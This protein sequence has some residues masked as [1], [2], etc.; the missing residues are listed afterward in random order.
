[1]SAFE[2]H[3]DKV[4]DNMIDEITKNANLAYTSLIE[5]SPVNELPESIF[6]NYFLPCFL[7]KTD[8][9]KWVLEWI[10]IAGSP[11]SEVAIVKDGTTQILY[12]VPGMLTTNNLFLQ[13]NEGSMSDIFARHDQINNNMP[14]ESMKYLSSAL[15]HTYGEL[16][17]S[18]SM[19]RTQEAWNHIFQRYNIVTNTPLQN[20]TKPS[21]DMFDY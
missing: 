2:Q 14:L 19:S 3:L 21:E 18:Y 6:V 17:N 7:G 12:T 13:R 10:S 11:T 5:N 1:M 20:T 8:N 15:D 4:R 16:M 9:Q